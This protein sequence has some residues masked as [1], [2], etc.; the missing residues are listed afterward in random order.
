MVYPTNA[1]YPTIQSGALNQALM[2][3]PVSGG[4]YQGSQQ[5]NINF[6]AQNYQQGGA[7]PPEK[8]KSSFLGKVLGIGAAVVGAVALRKTSIAKKAFKAVGKEADFKWGQTLGENAKFWKKGW[9]KGNDK[10]VAKFEKNNKYSKFI[11]KEGNEVA[12]LFKHNE[13]GKVVHIQNAKSNIVDIGKQSDD[14]MK[15]YNSRFGKTADAAEDG[16]NVGKNAGKK[17]STKTAKKL[18]TDEKLMKT[19]NPE[20]KEILS[21]YKKIIKDKREV[22][23]KLDAAKSVEKPDGKLINKLKAQINKLSKQ[24]TDYNKKYGTELKEIYNKQQ[25]IMTKEAT[26]AQKAVSKLKTDDLPPFAG[27]G[28]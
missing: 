24:K 22:I 17:G 8:K 18:S 1:A 5:G 15:K 16:V 21:N 3:T 26:R 9:F 12:N 14:L 19:L 4:G 11:D 2:Q 25:E 23:S 10:M 7:Y 27:E 20:Q 28:I 6:A 13:T